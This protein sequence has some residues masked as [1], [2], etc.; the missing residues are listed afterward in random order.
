MGYTRSLLSYDVGDTITVALVP[1]VNQ[2]LLDQFNVAMNV[3][4]NDDNTFT[5][6]EGST[7]PTTD[8]ENCSTYSTV[9]SVTE[10]GTWVGTPGFDH[11]DDPNAHSMGWGI[12]LSSVF[13][14]FS[15]PDLVGGTYGVDYGVGTD[16][17]LIHI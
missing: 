4:L 2:F 12:S 8:T 10:N 3:D 13:A 1:L 16:L 11:P 7:Y 5:I 6:N 17:S 9:P 15:A 14:Q